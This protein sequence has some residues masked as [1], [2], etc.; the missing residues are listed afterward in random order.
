MNKEAVELIKLYVNQTL[1]VEP[2][3]KPEAYN[4]LVSL[5][6]ADKEMAQDL[7]V[8]VGSASQNINNCYIT[9]EN[10]GFEL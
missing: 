3:I 7:H 8:L 10:T 5:L 4:T 2:G 9:E 6:K 1:T